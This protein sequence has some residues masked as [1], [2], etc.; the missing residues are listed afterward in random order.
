MGI[1]LP[2]SISTYLLCNVLEYPE[3]LRRTV[4]QRFYCGD[5][6]DGKLDGVGSCMRGAVLNWGSVFMDSNLNLTRGMFLLSD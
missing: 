2:H 4:S 3:G 1:L 5:A 6:R